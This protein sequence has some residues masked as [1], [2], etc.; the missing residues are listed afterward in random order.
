[1]TADFEL[2]K[3]RFLEG[4]AH[5]EAD[6]LA[7]A[8]VAFEASLV[9]LPGRPST[10]TNLAAVRLRQGRAAEALPLLDEAAA[11]EPDNL[12]T[13]CHR[14]VALGELG[15]LDEALASDDKALAVDAGCVPALRHRGL[16]L[17]RLGRH[18][19]ALATYNEWTR[20]QPHHAHAWMHQGEALLALERHGEALAAFDRCLAIDSDVAHAWS[21]R[22]AILKQTGHAEDA[23]D[24]FE[25]A[26]TLGA[27]AEMNGFLLASVTGRKAPAS[28]PRAYVESLFDTYA[29]D[30][31]A[32][33]VE[34]LRYQGHTHLVQEL[35]AHLDAPVGSALDLGCGTGLCAPLLR[36][37]ALG[38]HGVDVSAVMVEH[39][40]ARGIY[41][42]VT[43]ADVAEYLAGTDDRQDLVAAADVFIYLGDLAPVFAGA[44]RVLNPG[45]VFA[46]TVEKGEAGS[47]YAL[48]PSL[49]Y[50]HG[51]DYLRTLADA[52]GF[53]VLALTEAPIRHDQNQPIAGWYVVLRKLG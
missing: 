1:M 28:A 34:V 14:A 21:R 49:T 2:A 16:V 3:T 8:E 37:L 12:E 51:D 24:A 30:F 19:D 23:A 22:G 45:G 4:I 47:T 46:F 10:L 35:S 33:L 43:Q 39:A 26:I 6:R 17:Q 27:D 31:D 13:W 32:H 38:L 5:F 40:R 53:Q 41:D 52:H 29:P 36:P 7:E 9:A 11:G 42:S 20:L 44:R 15:R 25:R 50:R 18:A 48:A